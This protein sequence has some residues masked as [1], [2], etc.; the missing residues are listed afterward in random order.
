MTHTRKKVRFVA[1][2]PLTLQPIEPLVWKKL[3]CSRAEATPQIQ[4]L[5]LAQKRPTGHVQ[6]PVALLHAHPA[7]RCVERLL[8]SN[9][10]NKLLR[11]RR[12]AKYTQLPVAKV[13]MEHY[14]CKSRC[15]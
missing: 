5:F 12:P 10:T 14:K 4:N 9:G 2:L 13:H 7:A 3:L 15:P 8:R 6:P 1:Q 11:R